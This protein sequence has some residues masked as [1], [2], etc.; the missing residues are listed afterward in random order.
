MTIPEGLRYTREHEWVEI[1]DEGR[2]RVGITH[3]AQDELGDVVFVELPGVGDE[4]G[5]EDVFGTVESVKAVS[6]L[7]SP[8]TGKVI[9][10]NESLEEQPELVNEDP[11]GQGWMIQ[12]ELGDAAEL[13]GLMS[14][15]QYAAY[16]A[17]ESGH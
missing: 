13:D 15:E 2:G 8:V 17:E 12:V 5:G 10:V 14:A 11:Y 6:D 1:L 7:Y 4:L 3:H 9:Q 16:L